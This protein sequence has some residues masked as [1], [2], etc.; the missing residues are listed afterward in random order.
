MFLQVYFATSRVYQP[1]DIIR[2]AHAPHLNGADASWLTMEAAFDE[3]RPAVY[4]SRMSSRFACA[5]IEDCLAYYDAQAEAGEKRVYRAFMND[6]VS[7]PMVLTSYGQRH[8]AAPETL[9]AIA[10]EYW[11]KQLHGWEYL[12]Y[13]AA[14]LGVVDE[15]VERPHVMRMASARL[16]YDNDRER[17]TRIWS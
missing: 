10:H 2:L 16:S 7:V 6:P 14:E 11:A 15:V 9:A 13:L 8:H 3:A 5:T 4:P 17:A 12:E 1:G